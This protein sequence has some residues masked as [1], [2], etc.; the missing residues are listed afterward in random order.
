MEE[1]FR[2][3]EGQEP[4]KSTPGVRSYAFMPCAAQ[5]GQGAGLAVSFNG[6]NKGLKVDIKEVAVMVNF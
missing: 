6:D 2:L 5:C 1:L 4:P 3:S